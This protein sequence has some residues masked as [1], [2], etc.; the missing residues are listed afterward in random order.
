MIHFFLLSTYNA[1]VHLKQSSVNYDILVRIYS[2]TTTSVYIT[3]LKKH[4]K[5]QHNT[6]TTPNTT[7]HFYYHHLIPTC[8]IIYIYIYI[9]CNIPSCNEIQ[10]SLR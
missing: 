7:V 4:L 8:I 5:N 9:Y 1:C 2:T 10:S 6:F 3:T